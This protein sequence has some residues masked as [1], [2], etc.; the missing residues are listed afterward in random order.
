MYGK[1]AR[2]STW[3]RTHNQAVYREARE[4]EVSGDREGA[5]RL[6]LEIAES[7]PD[8]EMAS[9]CLYYAGRMA[10][11]D[12]DLETALSRLRRVIEEYH[13]KGLAPQA[14]RRAVQWST[15][16][17]GSD[18]AIEFLREMEPCVEGTD[19]HDTLLYQWAL[20]EEEAGRWERA[21]ELLERLARLYPRPRS[22]IYDDAMWRAANIALDHREPRRAL[23]YLQ[24]L[25]SWREDS[26]A[27]GSYYTPWTGEAQLLIGRIY[28]EHL[29]EPDAAVRA[30]EELATFP[31]TR[32]ADDGLWWAFR[33]HLAQGDRRQGCGALRRLLEQFPHS[34]YYRRAQE[35][36]AEQGC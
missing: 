7:D 22:T 6:Y 15:E 23:T 4:L 14:V 21:L 34:S 9:R 5:L 20:L 17:H 13:H 33:A 8:G 16:R 26:I 32:F 29:D 25:V 1:A 19:V 12:G 11:E 10:W 30:F 2:E 28:L 24:D 36:H 27:T 3:T 31:D 35:S 18:K